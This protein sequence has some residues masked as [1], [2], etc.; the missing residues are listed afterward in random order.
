MEKDEAAFELRPQEDD[1]YCVSSLL[2]V[3]N[4][5]GWLASRAHYV[6]S[7]SNTSENCQ[8]RCLGSLFR[9]DFNIRRTEVR[10][11]GG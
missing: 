5:T 7:I 9:N 11:I 6:P 1:V 2:K 10:L 3:D 4:E 8:N